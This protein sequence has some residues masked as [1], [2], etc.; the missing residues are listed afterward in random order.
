VAERM[1]DHVVGHH[2]TMPG[3][4]NTAQGVLATRRLKDS[5]H[6]SMMT[7]GPY[8][9]K[10]IAAGSAGVQWG[11]TQSAFPTGTRLSMS[12]ALC[13]VYLRRTADFDCIWAGR[14]AHSNR[15][16]RRDSRSASGAWRGARLA[17]GS[18]SPRRLRPDPALFAPAAVADHGPDHGA[19]A[20]SRRARAFAC[21]ARGRRP[22]SHDPIPFVAGARMLTIGRSTVESSITSIKRGG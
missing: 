15:I 10:A 4:G 22:R 9:C 2:S 16:Q 20:A 7:I 18:R 17:S 6:G 19:G 3:V 5:L 21:H 13:S 1:A 12:P 14:R 8:A 11:V